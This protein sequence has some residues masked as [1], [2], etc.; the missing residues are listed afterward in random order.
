MKHIQGVLFVLFLLFVTSSFAQSQM[1]Y[2]AGT[3]LAGPES[4]NAPSSLY[5]INPATGNT[6]RSY[7]F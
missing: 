3:G 6:D 2:G 7:R 4:G 1:L 5:M